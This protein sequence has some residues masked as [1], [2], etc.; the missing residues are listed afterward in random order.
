MTPL[1]QLEII[2]REIESLP[3]GA[4]PPHL[5]LRIREWTQKTMALDVRDRLH[6]IQA[7][8]STR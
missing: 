1:R 6:A 8:R 7:N 4:L 2:D 3:D 5:I